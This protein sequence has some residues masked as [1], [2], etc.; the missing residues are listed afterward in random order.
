M[1]YYNT[2]HFLT[3]TPVQNYHSAKLKTPFKVVFAF[4]RSRTGFQPPMRKDRKNWVNGAN[5]RQG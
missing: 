5:L 2:F 4:L 3:V 1:S